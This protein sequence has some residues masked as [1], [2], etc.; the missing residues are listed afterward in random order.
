[1]I[2]LV[3]AAIS[4]TAAYL[5]GRERGRYLV[6]IL[7]GATVMVSVDYLLGYIEEGALLRVK[8][9]GEAVVDTLI[10]L[11]MVIAGLTLWGLLEVASSIARRG[12]A[13]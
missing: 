6:L 11:A 13:R 7:W 9:A 5:A 8:D 3:A 4:A 2:P 10:G 1:M 12:R